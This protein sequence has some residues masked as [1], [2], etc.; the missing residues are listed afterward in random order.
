MNS[1]SLNIGD[2][3]VTSGV[4]AKMIR[5]YEEIGLIPKAKRTASGYRM[6]SEADI[7]VLRFIKHARKLGFSIKQIAQLL[8]LWR[9]H[10]RSSSKVKNLAVEH[11]KEL[12]EKILEMHAMKATLEDLVAHCHG[13]NRPECPILDELAASQAEQSIPSHQTAEVMRRARKRKTQPGKPGTG[14]GTP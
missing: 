4:S 2:T 9:D 14:V 3:A 8:S 6:Y 1:L 10:R 7:H 13:D 12:E 11:I 5:H